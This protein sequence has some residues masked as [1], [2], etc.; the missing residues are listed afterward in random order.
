MKKSIQIAGAFVSLVVGAG[1]ASG[2][3]IMQ[4]F[5]SFGIMSIFGSIVAAIIFAILGM[6]LAQIGSD[7]QTTS[8]KEGVH[9]IGGRFF[10]PVLDLLISFVL[11]G[12]SIVMF[13]G[14]GSTFNQMY[15][16]EAS[17]GSMLMALAVIFTLLLNAESII[18][19]IAT[20]TPYLMGIIF[21]LLIYSVFTMD[22]AFNE[23]NVM[24]KNQPSATSHWLSGA[25]LYVSYNITAGAAMLIV[26]GGTTKDRKI[27]RRGGAL[28]GIVL[29]LLILLINAALFAK[30]NVVAAV[31]MPTLELAQQIH[32][33]VGIIMS[34]ILLA[35]IYSTAVGTLYILAV[36]IGNPQRISFKLIVMLLCLVGFAISLV[37]FTTLIGKLYAIMGYFGIILIIAILF[38]W[39]R[40]PKR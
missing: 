19:I 32:P 12:I 1:F 9:Y 2:Q 21:I 8:H 7:L 17:F 13:A 36:R 15:S 6:T 29:G 16:I 24:A 40:K 10:G 25:I 37:G 31:E 20:L 30:M 33:I 18:K 38:S 5:T 27:A 11:F 28:G 14:A 3:E 39:L 22:Y 26:M 23:L 4:Y 35:M 34:V